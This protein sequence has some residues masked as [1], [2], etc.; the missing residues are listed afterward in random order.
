VIGLVL[1]VLGLT[2]KVSSIP[3]HVWAPD[4]YQGSPTPTTALLAT[5]SKAAGFVVLLRIMI[6]ALGGIKSEWVFF[7]SII[8]A[9]SLI[10][11]NLAAMPQK[12]IKRLIAYAGIGSAGYLLMAIAAASSLGAGAIMFYM[13]TYVFSI[14][15]TFLAVVIFYNSEGSD[16]IEDYAGLSLR[17]PLLAATLFIGLLSAAGVPPLGGFIAKFYII[18]SAVKE[19]LLVL[20]VIGV[21]MAIVS[22]YYFLL[23]VKSMYLR[24][25]VNTEP[26]KVDSGSRAV[27]YVI[28]AVT[29]F[30]GVY[31]GPFTDWVMEIAKQ[32]F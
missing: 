16:N 31:P 22:M 30:L 14:L 29:I 3:F 21:V 24:P 11:G 2:F 32:L 4:V 18:A 7:V 25:P 9:A 12:D 17:S 28:N 15:G 6:T 5:A 8:S 23:V 26:I 19:G 20:A 13:L 27:L 1:V 10:F